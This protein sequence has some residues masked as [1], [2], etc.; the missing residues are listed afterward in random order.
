MDVGSETWWDE[1]TPQAEI[2][3]RQRACNVKLGIEIA[4]HLMHGT[5]RIRVSEEITHPDNPG[6]PRVVYTLRATIEP[7]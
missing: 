3:R 4:P 6:I 7:A 2:D 1:R 5:V